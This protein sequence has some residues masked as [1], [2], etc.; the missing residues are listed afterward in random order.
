MKIE[1]SLTWIQLDK[2]MLIRRDLISYIE[3]D[4]VEK[5]YSIVIDGRTR[6]FSKKDGD[7]VLLAMN[8]TP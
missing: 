1:N 2:N 6:T 3:W 8:I 4:K 7:K 5:E